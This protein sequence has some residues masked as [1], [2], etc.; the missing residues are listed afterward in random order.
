MRFDC[1]PSL[2]DANTAL[3]FHYYPTVWEPELFSDTIAPAERRAKFRQ[4]LTQVASI[5]DTFHRPILCG[6]A[7][8]DIDKTNIG[9]SMT[10][11][12]ETLDLFR[13]FEISWTLWCYKDAQFMGLV[14]PKDD[15]PWMRFVDE[16]HKS[17][18][19][20]GEMEQ[21]ASILK[22]MCSSEPFCHAPKELLYYMQFRQR[23]ILYCLQAECILIPLLK[24]YS[25]DEI[26]KL[27]KS[28]AFENCGFY[29]E[30]AKLLKE[31]LIF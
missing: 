20:Y 31:E 23:G 24:T 21:A 16:I 13:E 22:N 11:L 17:W 26:L 14:Y 12:K 2:Q 8:Y 15:S 19:H 7:G 29:P 4:V 10:I 6:E 30:Y 28:F 9:H 25:A 27:P 3:T 18:T 1:I 5:R